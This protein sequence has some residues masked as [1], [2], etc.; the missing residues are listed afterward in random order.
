MAR[1]TPPEG[2]GPESSRL[3][4]MV[5]HIGHGLGAMMTALYEQC[6]LPVREREAMRMRIAQLNQC[7]L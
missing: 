1:I 2:D 3:W 7:H 4:Q 5:P 6:S